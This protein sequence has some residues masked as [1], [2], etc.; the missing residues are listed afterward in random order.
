[1]FGLGAVL[2]KLLSGAFDPTIIGVLALGAGG[3][4]LVGCLTLARKPLLH[5][6]RALSRRDWLDLFLLACP[7]TALPLLIIVAGFARTSAL[8]GG[9]LLQLNGV[10]ALLL[11]VLLLGERILVKQRLGVLLLL[12]GGALIVV[13]GTGGSGGDIA[14]DLL[15]LVGAVGVGFSYIPAKRLVERIHPLPLSA[16]RL[17]LGALSIL[18]IAAL[19]F[20][21]AGRTL[22]WQPSLANLEFLL[23]YA[24][25]NFCL[26]FLAQQ[27]G[28]RLLKAWQVAAIGQTVPLFSTLFAIL[29]L[30]DHLTLLQALG[31][32]LAILGGVIV[33]LNNAAPPVAPA[34]APVPHSAEKPR[35]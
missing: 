23:F 24:I 28:L 6:L 10:A 3:L 32:L 22:L 5:P 34:D 1:M 30:H 14:G 31:G 29:L 27:A 2:A 7:G 9:L 16:I 11:A 26:A 35:V 25:T 4:L 13:A 15:I 17:L 8:E 33:S 19:Q 20:F 12:L 18:P 21:I